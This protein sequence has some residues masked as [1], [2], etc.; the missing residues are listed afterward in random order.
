M[1]CT[2]CGKEAEWVENKAVY[3]RN[4]GKSYMIWLCPERHYV[5]CHNNTKEAKGT[6]ADKE[7]RKARTEAH[8][9]IDPLWKKGG[10]TRRSV[11]CALADHFGRPIHIG[12]SSKE[13]CEEIIRVA[14]LL[15]RKLRTNPLK[16]S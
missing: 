5:G 9:V 10:K 16:I 7:T 4:F 11:Y 12:E 13:E 1:E 3:G 14:R 6:F 8:A 2:I 15:F